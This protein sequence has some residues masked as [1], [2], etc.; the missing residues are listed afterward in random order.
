M[1]VDLFREEEILSRPAYAAVAGEFRATGRVEP[2]LLVTAT[3]A[4]VSDLQRDGVQLAVLDALLPFIAS[5]LAWGHD[6]ETISAFLGDL[7]AVLEP[8]RLVVVYLDGSVPQALDR[9]VRREGDSWLSWLIARHRGTAEPVI[10]R[11]SLDR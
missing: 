9:A 6:E 7:T 8:A 2:Q 11:H 1:T 10:D 3:A 4:L 5:M